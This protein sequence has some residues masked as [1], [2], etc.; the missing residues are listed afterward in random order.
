MLNPI[1]PQCQDCHTGIVIEQQSQLCPRCWVLRFDAARPAPDAAIAACIAYRERAV[2]QFAD[3]TTLNDQRDARIW[4]DNA[5]RNIAKWTA[6][7]EREA[8][9]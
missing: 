1:L 6:K 8:A 7:L 9:R 4:I 5:D 2:Q 3:A